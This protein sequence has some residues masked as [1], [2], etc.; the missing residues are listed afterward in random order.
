ML[1]RRASLSSY[2]KTERVIRNVRGTMY[3]VRFKRLYHDHV[4]GSSSAT[5]V[6][7]RRL[8]TKSNRA[9]SALARSFIFFNPLPAFTVPGSKPFPLSE[10]D[11][12]NV[13]PCLTN[14]ISRSVA[15]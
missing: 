10:T 12:D 6:P 11:S 3:D 13:F 14:F 2:N 9:L 15:P 4:R 5:R 1:S 8:V 7:L